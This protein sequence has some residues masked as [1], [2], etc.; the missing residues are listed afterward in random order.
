MRDDNLRRVITAK[1]GIK[2]QNIDKRLVRF[3]IYWAHPE[4]EGILKHKSC[5]K[6][7]RILLNLHK[8]NVL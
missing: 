5:K 6:F 2:L 7:K 1:N 4:M 3:A 8:R